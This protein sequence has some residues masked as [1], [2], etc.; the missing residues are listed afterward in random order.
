MNAKF[1]WHY[2]PLWSIEDSYMLC[3]SATSE[4]VTESE[5]FTSGSAN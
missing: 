5:K 3:I 4:T 1:R 2:I